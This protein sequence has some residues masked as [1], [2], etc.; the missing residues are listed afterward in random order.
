MNK[1]AL[2]A[3]AGLIV[4]A[5]LFFFGRTV[6]KKTAKPVSNAVAPAH[7]HSFDITQYI[8]AEKQKLTASQTVTVNKLE[9]NITRGDITA[10][11]I[12]SNKDLA[13]FW[14]DSVHAFE[15]YVYYLSAA[16]KLENSEKNLTF[17][18]QLILENLKTEQDEV[19]LD[20]QTTKA[21]ELF[22]QALKLDPDNDNLKIGLGSCYIYGRSRSGD[23]QQTMKGVLQLRSVVEKDSN[24]MKAQL[25]LGI[26]GFISRQY[27]KA[28]ERL[29]KVVHFDPKNVEAVAYLADAYEGKGEKSEALKWYKA[30]NQLVTNPEAKK[31]IADKIKALE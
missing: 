24:N 20:W 16:A 27:D 25:V 28:I 10:Q 21:I 6:Q 4:V 2:L 29:L 3:T 8:S 14:K 13:N 15:P 9:N 23:P 12:A 31:Q 17:A 30:L 5:V 11:Q 26:G 1:Q 19:K 7:T 18:A 22:E